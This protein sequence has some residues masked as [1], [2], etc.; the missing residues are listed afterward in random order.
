M[1]IHMIFVD[2]LVFTVVFLIESAAG[3]KSAV[4][5][6]ND[7]REEAVATGGGISPLLREP[8]VAHQLLFLG[9]ETDPICI[10]V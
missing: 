4:A 3:T 1:N 9:G 10:I 7:V 8:Y 2:V 5:A 6:G